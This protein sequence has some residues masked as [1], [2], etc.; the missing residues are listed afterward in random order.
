MATQSHEYRGYRIVIRPY[1]NGW[2]AT[3]YAPS[4]TRPILGPHSDDPT[5]QHDILER[6]KRL[7][8][9]LMNS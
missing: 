1:G 3:I 5:S 4:S 2:R 6:A 7:V 8:D 9:N